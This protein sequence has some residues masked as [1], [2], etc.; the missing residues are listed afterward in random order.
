MVAAGIITMVL[1]CL[2]GAFIFLGWIAPLVI[3][4]SWQRQNTAGSRTWIWFS[5]VWAG[6]AAVLVAGIVAMVMMANSE[7][8]AGFGV[9]GKVSEFSAASF[10]G[11]AGSIKIPFA[12]EVHFTA[13]SEAPGLKSFTSSNGVFVVPAGRIT[14]KDLEVVANDKQSR[15]WTAKGRW[16]YSGYYTTNSWEVPS[17]GVMDLAIGPPFKASIKVTYS[18]ASDAL[19]MEPEYSDAFGNI[20]SISSDD[21]KETAPG[22]ELVDGANKI[23]MSGKFEFG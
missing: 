6:M 5:V 2:I 23:V 12:G 11:P 17:G 21:R 1:V 10:K 13:E 18:A 3:G 15:K 8:R 20:Y 4:L 7:M 16:G 22:F 14:I 19:S 9:T